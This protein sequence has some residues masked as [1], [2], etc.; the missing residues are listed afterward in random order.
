MSNIQSIL[1]GAGAFASR[2]PIPKKVKLPTEDGEIEVELFFL[3]L[4]GHDVREL[5]KSEG[6]ARDAEFIS[7]TLCNADGSL[8]LEMDG[9]HGAMALKHATLQALTN[10]AL[11]SLGLTKPEKASAK[12]E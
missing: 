8:A 3:D 12:N 10:A 6:K 5:L 2:K 1:G 7:R 9:E 11:E 4:P